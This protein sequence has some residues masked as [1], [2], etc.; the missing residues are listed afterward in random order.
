MSGVQI[1]NY[2]NTPQKEAN[3]TNL[4]RT[5]L[6]IAGGAASGWALS[7]GLGYLANPYYK[8]FYEEMDNFTLGEQEALLKLSKETV[9]K[10][11]I[12]DNGF[13][14]ITLIDP[15]KAD[16]FSES[17]SCENLQNSEKFPNVNKNINNFISVSKDI[18][19]VSLKEANE[20][21]VKGIKAT[22]DEGALIDKLKIKFLRI[23]RPFQRISEW[24]CGKF[25]RNEGDLKKGLF[26]TYSN[27]VFTG[28][29][30]SLPHEVQH[31]INK[32]GKFLARLPVNLEII[33]I[34]LL[35]PFVI[36]NA[37]FTKK[38]QKPDEKTQ[39]KRSLFKK[40][41]DFTHNHIGLTLAGLSIPLLFEEGLA[42]FRAIKFV[43]ASEIIGKSTK[44]QHNKLLKI[45]FGTYLI[46]TAMIALTAQ[47]AVFVKDKIVEYKPK[48]E[49]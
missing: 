36:L 44:I 39:D 7:K 47:L 10:S 29:L 46:Q 37:M 4:P 11:R 2:V 24:L 26:E 40:I 20:I 31:A 35:I 9:E 30:V 12:Q 33:S 42:S 49:N 41:R 25:K 32:N 23:T 3:Q 5:V 43:N 16:S 17:I 21:M 34:G 45:A 6:G 18:E 22:I 8:K 28:N 38:S 14:G 19:K 13:K 27:R 15:A 1:Q 48:S